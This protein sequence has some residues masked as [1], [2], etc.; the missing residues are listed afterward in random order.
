MEFEMNGVIYDFTSRSNEF[1]RIVAGDPG[2][3][4]L[5]NAPESI[6][7]EDATRMIKGGYVGET[8]PTGETADGYTPSR[9][10]PGTSWSWASIPAEK[11]HLYVKK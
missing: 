6:S 9:I 3:V 8:E 4:F 1:D 10:V 2:G 11:M 5:C 7:D